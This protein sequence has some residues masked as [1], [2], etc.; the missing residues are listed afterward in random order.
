MLKSVLAIAKKIFKLIVDVVE[1]FVTALGIFIIVYLFLFQPHQVRGGSMLPNFHDKEYILTN[2]M[3]YYFRS[4]KRG[5]VV[6]FESP[7]NKNYDYIKR[8]IGMPG[9]EISL[10]RGKIYI[11]EKQLDET[12]YLPEDTI[13]PGGS[14]LKNG[15]QIVIPNKQYFVI[16]D[17]RGNS[18]DSRDWG[19]IPRDNIIG[20][21]WLRYWPLQ[22][23]G[24]L[25]TIDW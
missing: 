13:T 20:K 5:D 18:S 6:I 19:P 15:E 24:F 17:N 4:P 23:F 11:N 3:V 9:E 14:F 2:K 22:N 16:G 7:Q 25:P 12:K 8:I 10:K 21:A 1:A